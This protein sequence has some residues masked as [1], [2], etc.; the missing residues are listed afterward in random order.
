L[1]KHT[2]EPSKELFQK[3]NL[4]DTPENR[5]ELKKISASLA[6]KEGFDIQTHNRITA[7]TPD[8]FMIEVLQKMTWS[9]Y[10]AP[11]PHAFLTSDNL[12]R[13][14]HRLTRIGNSCKSAQ[15]VSKF[16]PADAAK[17]F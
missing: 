17:L 12:K 5:A 9:F 14:F 4:P 13:G 6:Q 8:S 1:S 15:S 2:Y 3:A 10:F 7:A 16:S 11:A